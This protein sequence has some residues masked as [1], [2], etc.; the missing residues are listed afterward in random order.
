MTEREESPTEEQARD[1]RFVGS[2]RERREDPALLRG[3]GQFTDDIDAPD[4]SHLV[5]VRSPHAHADV[6]EVETARAEGM[7][8]V[9]AAYTWA[10]VEASDAHGRMGAPTE[11]LNG[12]VPGHPVLADGRVRYQGQPVAAVVAE[13]P[14]LAAD[15]AEAVAVE[16]D[17]LDAVTDAAA[18]RGDDAP[19]VFEGCPDNVAASGELGDEAATDAA[20]ADADRVVDLDLVNN[21]LIPNALE[22]RAALARPEGDRLRVDMTSQ[23][24]HGHRSDLADALDVPERDL[25]VVAPDVGGG[26]GHKGHHHPGETMAAWA[27]RRLD[28][29][30]KWT[31]TRSE[32]YLAGAHGRDHVTTCALAFDD[33]GRIRGLRA[34]TD[35]NVGGYPLGSSPLLPLWYG[36]LLAGQYDV[37]AIHCVTRSVF[38]TT[39]PVHSYRGAGRPE[40]IYVLERLVR[41]AAD[42]LGMD[43]AEFRRRN[44]LPPDAFPVET[45]AGATYDSGDYEPALERA[46]DAVDYETLRETETRDDGRLVGVGLASFVEST[47]GGFES[48]VVRVHPDGGVTAFAGTHSHGQGHATT[49]AQVV[50]DELGMNPDDVDVVEGDTDRIPRGTGT[51]GSRSVVVGGGAIVESAREVREKAA[52]IAAD[53]LEADPGDVELADGEFRI[54]GAPERSVSFAAVAAAAHGSDRPE[55]MDAGLEATS[56]FEPERSAYA[57]GTHAAVVAV[58]PETGE[59]EVDRYVAVD[60]CGVRVNPTLV[61]GQIHGGVAQGIRQALHERAVYDED[62]TLASG[63]MADYKVPDAGHVPEIHTEHT[64]TPSPT[65]P[66]GAK[67]IGEAGTIAAPPAVVNAVVDALA[68]YGVDHVDMPVTPPRVWRAMRDS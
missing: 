49:Y 21:R 63:T 67:G 28:R 9:V 20:F 52:R 66:L 26:F 54:A 46:L 59:V 44:L 6:V 61:E 19:T 58:D 25:R 62:G 33:D 48:G 65:N 2:A 31:A 53:E 8:G 5:F 10:D 56:F 64:V 36:R 51:F 50:A 41:R 43:P 35:A 55:G 32:N 34:E 40:A 15:A 16:Y 29:P 30:V 37:P 11:R 23:S 42:D 1:A 60:D 57:F 12:D 39:A 14:Y 3:E 17:R 38:T 7:D 24:P 45:A 27:A 4:A 47:G 68:P 13:S 18:A 22:P